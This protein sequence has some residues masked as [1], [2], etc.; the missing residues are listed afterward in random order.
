MLRV[1]SL[2]TA[3]LL[4]PV[5]ALGWDCA[6]AEAETWR[7]S[8]KM[9]AESVEG[10]LFQLFADKIEEYTGGA[11]EVAVYPSEQLGKDDTVLEQLQIGTI[12]IYPEAPE[13]LQKWVPDIKWISA[14]FLFDDRDHWVRFMNSDLAQGWFDTVEQE[15]GIAVIGDPTAFLRG[16]YR[17]MVSSVEWNTL[18]EMRGLKLRMHPE[19]LSVQAWTHLGA[20]VQVLPWTDVYESIGR[21]VV[22]GVNTPIAL[23]EP[24]KFYEVAPYVIRHDEFP[25]G[26]AFMTNAE[27]WN[28]LDDDTRAAILRAYDEMAEESFARTNA[29][30]E[31]DV[32][33]M[34][35]K[36]VAFS[37]AETSAFVERMKS[38]Y[39]KMEA[40]GQLPEGF[41][42]VVE[43]TRQQ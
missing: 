13:Y 27:S 28:G 24:M 42:D 38:F 36:G 4:A 21:G 20:E 9:P 8:H 37:T 22:N 34:E 39:E 2:P 29:V 5:L 17:V 10:Q 30:T 3:L 43:E 33:T 23:V 15:A 18:E 14:P 16:P 26:M 41:L 1:K 31:K 7:M 12:H 40:S 6:T 35:E 32:T 19:D 11:I 25:Q